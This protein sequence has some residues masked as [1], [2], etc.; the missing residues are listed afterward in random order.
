[1]SPVD[2][3]ISDANFNFFVG[4]SVPDLTNVLDSVLID[5]LAAVLLGILGDLAGIPAIPIQQWRRQVVILSKSTKS[6]K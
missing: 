5:I 1:M 3:S 2:R 4:N 6:K